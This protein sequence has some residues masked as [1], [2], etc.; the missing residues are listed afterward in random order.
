MFAWLLIFRMLVWSFCK[1]IAALSIRA[2]AAISIH[3]FY[4]WGTLLNVRVFFFAQWCR[5]VGQLCVFSSILSLLMNVR[6]ICYLCYNNIAMNRFFWFFSVFNV[7]YLYQKFVHFP[8]FF[9]PSNMHHHRCVSLNSYNNNIS[10]CMSIVNRFIFM[11]A[12]LNGQCP[13]FWQLTVC[14]TYLYFTYMQILYIYNL[15]I[16]EFDCE[17]DFL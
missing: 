14:S 12:L 2:H 6:Q 1:A 16:N 13:C 4:V 10:P 7:I 3:T 15:E 11:S 17:N 5:F 8:G 9:Y